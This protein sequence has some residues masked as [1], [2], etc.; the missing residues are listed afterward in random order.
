MLTAP[1]GETP[2]E[3]AKTQSGDIGWQAHCKSPTS[4]GTSSVPIRRG[5]GPGQTVLTP[6]HKGERVILKLKQRS[7]LK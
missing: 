1:H 2:D 3:E 6:K 5:H 7:L 4:L